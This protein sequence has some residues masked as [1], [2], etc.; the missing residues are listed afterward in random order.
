MMENLT[1][2]VMLFQTLPNQP[3][4]MPKTKPNAYMF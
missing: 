3:R 1:T 4:N 2:R